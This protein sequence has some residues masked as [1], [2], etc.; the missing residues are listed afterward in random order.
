MVVQALRSSNYIIEEKQDVET[1][2]LTLAKSR[3]KSQRLALGKIDL[4][5]GKIDLDTGKIDLDSAM[6]CFQ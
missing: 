2:I 4:D 3:S 5:T 1:L 6:A